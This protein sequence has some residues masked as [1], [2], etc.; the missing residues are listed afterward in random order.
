LINVQTSDWKDIHDAYAARR[1]GADSVGEVTGLEAKDLGCGEN[2]KDGVKELTEKINTVLGK[3][4]AIKMRPGLVSP[5]GSAALLARLFDEFKRASLPGDG[6]DNVTRQLA[7]ARAAQDAIEA[8]YEKLKTATD[9]L[10][11][12]SDGIG[13]FLKA[14]AKTPLFVISR[15]YRYDDQYNAKGPI[16]ITLSGE[17]AKPLASVDITW[18]TPPRVTL[19]FGVGISTLKRQSFSNQAIPKDIANLD[20]TTFTNQIAGTASSLTVL[21]M[22]LLHVR[23]KRWGKLKCDVAFSV[24]GGFNP[25]G[26]TPTGEAATGFSFGVRNFYL[27]P[28]LHFGRQTQLQPGYTVKQKVTDKY[29]PLTHD[30]WTP[31]FGFAITYRLPL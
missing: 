28:L 14:M 30:V 27:S 24:G 21:P 12:A 20:T 6:L 31:A 8:E 18:A 25:K 19:S 7:K 16:S 10:Q 15:P 11:T 26:D 23:L 4:A 3:L 22:G 1:D 29:T 5:A 13:K 17:A 9:A 2:D